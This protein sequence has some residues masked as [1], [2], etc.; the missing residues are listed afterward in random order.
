VKGRRTISGARTKKIVAS[1]ASSSSREK[2]HASARADHSEPK[3]SPDVLPARPTR[4]FGRD[5]ELAVIRELLLT[6][7]VRLLTLT[8]P[9]GIGK[10]RL[11]LE[12][13]SDLRQ[14][15]TEGIAFVDLTPIRDPALVAHIIAQRLGMVRSP[16]RPS[17]EQ[18]THFLRGKHLLLLLDSFEHVVDAG[19]MVAD[20]LASCPRLRVLATSQEP[21]R[22]NWER[23]Y[24][25]PPLALPENLSRLPDT[26]RLIA[27][28]A[29]ALFTDRARAVHPRFMLDRQNASVIA[30]ICARLDGL[31]L[32]IEMAAALVKVLPPEA[33]NERLA[34]GLMQLTAGAKNLPSRHQTLRGAIFWSYSLLNPNEKKLFCRLAVFVSG[35]SLDAAE[36]VCA[37]GDSVEADILA[38]SASL[39]N[40]SLLQH[41]PQPDGQP[42]YSMLE[43]IRQFALE[44][45]AILGELQNMQRRH[46]TYFLSLAELAEPG[47]NTRVQSTWLSRLEW[48]HDNL[49]EVLRWSISDTGDR[50]TGLRLAGALY[51]FW[52][53]RGYMAEGSR[54]L[55]VL[56]ADKG[57]H[58]KPAVRAKAC[59]GAGFLAYRLGDLEVAQRLTEE[60]LI[61]WR[62]L[63]DAAGVA[64]ALIHLGRVALGQHDHSRA[65]SLWEEALAF[66]KES[67]DRLE[68]A[69]ALNGLGELARMEGDLQQARARYEECLSIWTDA[70]NTEMVAVVLFNLAQIAIRHGDLDRARSCLSESVRLHK[71]VGSQLVTNCALVGLAEVAIHE[72]DARRAARLFSAADALSEAYREV[73]NPPDQ[74]EYDSSLTKTRGALTE[75]EFAVARSEGRS[76]TLEEALE[77]ALA[78]APGLGKNQRAQRNGPLT[79]REGEVA[80]LVAE[81]LS[82]RQIGSRLS[83][84]ERT[85]ETHIGNILNK[86]N[87]HSR[88]Q[89]AAWVAEHV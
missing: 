76:L 16:T 39:V 8:G 36:A 65:R 78:S 14:H 66:N 7:D 60:G 63:G 32:A 77:Y 2:A 73:L 85:A 9:P 46:A 71:D 51:W 20:L 47:L 17:L 12:V 69:H 49:R 50:A 5:M 75:E 35:A 22:I 88:A 81:G 3:G 41:N 38:V 48:D 83:I 23:E 62:Q 40:K 74:A 53:I 86:L 21:L 13:V 54:W 58:V 33:L 27:Y 61:L 15:F 10:T 6:P 11:A 28:S 4:F 89:I 43:S 37:D 59:Y 19:L 79:R 1:R 82:N 18:L 34:H 87:F 67:G 44:Q 25:V 26:E 29:I 57:V 55:Q 30:A 56:L 72:G 31:P 24:P 64:K 42:R 84:A 45:L 68:S 52:W 70:G 80:A